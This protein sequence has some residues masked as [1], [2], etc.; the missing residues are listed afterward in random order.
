MAINGKIIYLRPMEFDD[1]IYYQDMINDDFI[2]S[3]VVGWSFPVSMEEQINWF[4]KASI[5]SNNKRFTIVLKESN[6]VVGM[7]TLTSIDWH[8]RS[9]TH[10]IKLLSS[11]PKG[12]GIGTDAVITLMKY[13]FDEVNLNRLDGSWLD[14]N[15]ASK[16]LYEKCG[17]YEEGCKKEAIYRNGRYHDL[18]IAGITKKE[19][20]ELKEQNDW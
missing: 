10:G 3:K 18:K 15:I 16:K 12:K 14:Y 13:A 6:E 2:A 8:N 1:M 5:D 17:W 9:A 7:L 20:L 19:Y 4:H 11:C